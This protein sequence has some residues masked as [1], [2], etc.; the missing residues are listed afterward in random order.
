MDPISLA[1]SISPE[2]EELVDLQDDYVTDPG[3]DD[4]KA[5]L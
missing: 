4:G 1:A 3:F 2:D 5:V